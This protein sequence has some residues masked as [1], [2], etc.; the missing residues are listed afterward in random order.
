MFCRIWCNANK[1]WS[2]EIH[3]EESGWKLSKKGIKSIWAT[4]AEESQ[5]CKE[6]IKCNCRTNCMKRCSWKKHNMKYTKLC[7]VKFNHSMNFFQN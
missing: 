1:K 5:V 2:E 6:L 3:I 7:G 4:L